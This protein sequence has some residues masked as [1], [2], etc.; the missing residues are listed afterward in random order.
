MLLEPW[1]SP[2]ERGECAMVDGANR[3][4]LLLVKMVHTVVWAF[5]VFCILAIPVLTLRG[6]L[7]AAAWFAGIVLVEVA[8]LAMNRWSCPLTPVAA[9]YTDERRDNFDIF[10]PE[11]LARHN[12]S[13]FGALYLAGLALLIAKW[14]MQR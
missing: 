3:S 6:R 10:L 12:K 8:V 2:G 7:M 9:R 13:I 4:A 14:I 11:W 1:I 5:F